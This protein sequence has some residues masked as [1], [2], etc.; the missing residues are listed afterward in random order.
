MIKRF[1]DICGN[2][3]TKD[4][5]IVSSAPGERLG[6]TIKKN[7][8]ELKVEILTS[9]DGTANKGDVCKHCVLDALY[10]LDDRPRAV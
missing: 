5:S 8:A 3:I 6:A 4:S 1:C 10:R 7:G 2:E 9:V